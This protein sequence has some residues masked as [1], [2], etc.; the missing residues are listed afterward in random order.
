MNKTI[1]IIRI[2]ILFVLSGIAMIFLF[3]EEQDANLATWMFRF[4]VDKAF[5]FVL[6]FNIARLY[7]RWSKIDPWFIAYEKKCNEAMDAPNPMYID[8]DDK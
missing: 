5:A 2:A 4:L 8:E 3:G 1:S 7:K 6:I